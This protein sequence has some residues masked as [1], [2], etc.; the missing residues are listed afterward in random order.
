[1]YEEDKIE[2]VTMIANPTEIIWSLSRHFPSFRTLQSIEDKQSLTLSK[3]VYDPHKLN[4]EKKSEFQ[5]PGSP[6]QCVFVNKE[7]LIFACLVPNSLK[8]FYPDGTE[9]DFILIIQ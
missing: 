4:L 1:M 5:I 8:G 7:T 3:N 2:E 6:H 9:V